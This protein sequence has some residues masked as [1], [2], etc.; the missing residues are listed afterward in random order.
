MRL[1]ELSIIQYQN[2]STKPHLNRLWLSLNAFEKQLDHIS[3]NGFRVLSMDAALQFMERAKK[4]RKTRPLSLTF[5]NGYRDFYDHAFPLLS[6]YEFPATVLVSPRKVGTSLT[7][8][9][10]KVEYLTWPMLKELAKNNVIIGAYEDQRWNIN[11]I[12]EETVR[13]HI[14]EY[15]KMLE[16]RLDVDIRYFGVKEGVPK[17]EIRDLLISEGYRAFLTECPTNKK[18]DLYAVGRIQVDD[19]DFNIFLTKISRTY[20]FFKDKKSWKYIREYSLDKA[21]HRLSEA[22]DRIKIGPRKKA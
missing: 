6:R 17:P 10:E 12:P 16:D 20:L 9:G 8:G 4:I 21:A 14:T 22:Y 19:D 15:K 18:P 1:R 11:D 7:V 13:E 2:V 5:D 3:R